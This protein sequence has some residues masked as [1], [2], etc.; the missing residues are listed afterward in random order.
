M[1][2]EQ[3]NALATLI[4]LRENSSAREA[5]K[6]FFV[7]RMSKPEIVRKLDMTTPKVFDSIKR[8][9]NGLALAKIAVGS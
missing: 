5:A 1:T 9:E 2:T 6:L 3:F 4:K 8:C 7:D